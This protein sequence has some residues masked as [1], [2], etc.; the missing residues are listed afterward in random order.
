MRFLY[1]EVLQSDGV[2]LKGNKLAW[3]VNWVV[4]WIGETGNGEEINEVE[5]SSP[6]EDSGEAFW[7]CQGNWDEE[8]ASAPDEVSYIGV[9]AVNSLLSLSVKLVA[10]LIHGTSEEASIDHETTKEK[11]SRDAVKGSPHILIEYADQG[12]TNHGDDAEHHHGVVSSIGNLSI[13]ELIESTKVNLLNTEHEDGSQKNEGTVV[14]LLV[15]NVWDHGPLFIGAYVSTC[16][17]IATGVQDQQ[18]G[19]T[20]NKRA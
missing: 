15:D 3:L 9:H 5:G 17:I 10:D 16:A 1:L 19:G 6:L 13:E 7:A 8:G 12:E 4:E 2:L 20:N 18:K 14:H 11:A